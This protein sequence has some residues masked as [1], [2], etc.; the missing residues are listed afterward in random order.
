VIAG[1]KQA[2]EAYPPKL[3][4]TILSDELWSA[5]FSLMHVRTFADRGDVYTT[6]GC[7]TRAASGLTQVLFAL[8]GKYF[9]RDKKALN[10]IAGFPLAP[11]GYTENIVRILGCPGDTSQ[12]LAR[13]IAEMDQAWKNVAALPGVDHRSKYWARAGPFPSIFLF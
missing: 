3:R 4:E 10:E 1:L 13:S 2:V 8:N 5:E 9:L 12:Q 7:L 6:A 11:V